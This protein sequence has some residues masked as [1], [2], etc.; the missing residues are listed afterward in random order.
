[1]KQVE[2]YFPLRYNDGSPVEANWI[3]YVGDELL[4]NFGGYTYFPQP[5]KGV[6]KLGHVTFHDEIV[7]FRVLTGTVRRPRQFFKALKKKLK[8][9][10]QQEEILIVAI[11]VEVF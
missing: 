11:D 8:K 4:A 9:A 3:D 2:V 1:V 6:W 5:N 10:L 7:I